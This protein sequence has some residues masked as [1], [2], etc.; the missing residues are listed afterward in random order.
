MSIKEYPT[1]QKE[2][3]KM[4]SLINIMNDTS[5]KV[6]QIL[7][8]IINKKS[9]DQFNYLIS[10]LPVNVKNKDELV[11]I[12]KSHSLNTIQYENE[13]FNKNELIKIVNKIYKW[14]LKFDILIKY[15]SILSYYLIK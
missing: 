12:I 10:T 6:I 15:T 1:I 3:L 11:N 7:K 4:D 2:N 8:K 14:W 9:N 13:N 5:P